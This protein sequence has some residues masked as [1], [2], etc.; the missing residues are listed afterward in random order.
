MKRLL[1]YIPWESD[2]FLCPLASSSSQWN[3]IAIQW[4]FTQLIF[5][6]K[7]KNVSEMISTDV[8]G[9]KFVV[10]GLH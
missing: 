4:K 7:N 3:T 8:L 1:D 9:S 2:C 6:L 10:L 5:I